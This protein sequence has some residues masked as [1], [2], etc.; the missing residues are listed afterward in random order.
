MDKATT[1]KEAVNCMRVYFDLCQHSEAAA[2]REHS[3]KMPTSE[4]SHECPMEFRPDWLPQGEVLQ[5]F[6]DAHD[7]FMLVAAESGRILFS[8]ELITSLLGHMQTRLVGQNIF[9]YVLDADKSC[10]VEAFEPL[11]GS[12]GIP[13]PNSSIIAFPSRTFQCHMKLYSGEA[14]C[15][16]HFLPFTFLSFLRRWTESEPRPMSPPLS[17]AGS[18]TSSSATSSNQQSCILLFGKLPT[19][20]TLIDLAVGTNDVN[21]EFEMRVSREG[22]IIDVD[23]HA[24]LIFG[25]ELSELIGSSFFDY[26]DPYHILDVG[27]SMSAFLTSGLGTTAPYRFCTKGGRYIWFIS[28]GYLSYNPWN[29]K[30]DRSSSVQT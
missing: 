30:P 23:K 20:L 8:T 9:D 25:F 1:L 12:S 15:F 29:H 11:D 22:K 4:K 16:P 17:P 28:K 14:S 13:L 6:L 10:L 7:T 21:F 26:V 19:S 3:P 18:E 27:E 24:V 5:F 2:K